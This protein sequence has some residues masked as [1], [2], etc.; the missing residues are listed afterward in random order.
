VALSG[1]LVKDVLE[2]RASIYKNTSD[3]T[4]KN[5]FLNRD[6]TQNIDELTA[7]LALRWYAADNHTI[8]FNFVHVNVDNG[9]DAFTFDNS[10]NS[11]A[12]EPGTDAQKTNAFAITSNYQ[13]NTGIHL[14]TKVS[15][16]QSDLTYSFDV[17]WTYEG[18]HPSVIVHLM[19]T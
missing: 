15:H 1:A 16:S 18:F 4:M 6:D 14:V 12:D 19:S 17:D 13:V 11:H 2:G 7:K 9:Y 3:G 8:D 10:R 5:V